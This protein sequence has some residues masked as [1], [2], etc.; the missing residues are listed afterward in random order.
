VIAG[1]A[2]FFM[3]HAARGFYDR[4]LRTREIELIDATLKSHRI[5]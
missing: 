2:D 4:M 5:C 3:C 1:T